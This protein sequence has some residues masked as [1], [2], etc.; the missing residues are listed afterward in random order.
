MAQAQL[1]HDPRAVGLDRLWREKDPLTD[2]A[3]GVSLRGHPEN[4]ALAHAQLLQRFGFALLLGGLV[5]LQQESRG[6]G[7]EK[8]LVACNDADGLDQ[9]LA[10]LRLVDEATA[11]GVE[12]RQQVFVF[13]MRRQ[14]EHTGRVFER[15]NAPGRLEPSDAGH[16]EVHDHDIRPQRCCA[17]H[18]LLARPDLRHDLHV[19]LEV[20]QRCQAGAQNAVVIGNDDSDGIVHRH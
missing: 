16:V 14:H 8:H 9:V 1:A 7:I 19:M 15:R 2:F 18:G 12:N 17:L 6:A 4:L 13:C 11:A 3:G 5:T 10:S 20:Q